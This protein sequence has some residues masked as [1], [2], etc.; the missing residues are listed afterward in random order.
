[1]RLTRLDTSV[2][3]EDKLLGHRTCQAN[4]VQSHIAPY[5]MN[6]MS[7]KP[8]NG[9]LFADV[10]AVLPSCYQK[11]ENPYAHAYRNERALVPSV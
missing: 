6:L 3:V 2:E 8:E 10:R 5:N 11:E 1:M 9:T 7:S 4:R